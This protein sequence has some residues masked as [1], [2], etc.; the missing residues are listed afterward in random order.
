VEIV[1]LGFLLLQ[2]KIGKPTWQDMRGTNVMGTK[3]NGVEVTL[4]LI[5]DSFSPI[6]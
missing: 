3:K 2:M 1:D 4:H 5:G 6:L